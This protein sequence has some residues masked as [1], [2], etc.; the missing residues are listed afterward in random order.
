M[1]R[2]DFSQ[3]EKKFNKMSLR[4]RVI[5]FAGVLICTFS[6][7]YFW[8]YDSAIIKQAK[9]DSALQKS[10]QQ[11]KKLNNE[12]ADIERRLQKDPLQEINTKIASSQKKLIALD[13]QLNEKL[14]KFIAAQKMP[15]ALAKVLSNSPGIKVESLTT[16]PVTVFK[17]SAGMAGD[18]SAQKQFFKHTLEIQLV[19][20]FNAIYQ[21]FLN[22]EALQDKF[23]FQYMA[24][25]V[26]DYPLAKVTIRIYTLSEQQDLVSG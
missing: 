4:E 17:S 20:S 19:G 25:Q 23:Y 10:Y 8:I 26:S 11:E 22:L 21:Y 15:I 16:L 24:Y 14:V 9:V 5:L 6:I 1:S 3:I 2:F 13:K 7:S 18:S 12:I